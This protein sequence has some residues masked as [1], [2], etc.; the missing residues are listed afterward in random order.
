MLQIHYYSLQSFLFHLEYQQ[1]NLA[2]KRFCKNMSVFDFASIRAYLVPKQGL[3]L[4]PFNENTSYII[5]Q[6]TFLLALKQTK[7]NSNMD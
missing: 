4:A 1:T 5:V 3:T 6:K 7:K 2:Q